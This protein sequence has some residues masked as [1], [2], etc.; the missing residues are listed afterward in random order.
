MTGAA[1]DR[2]A[3]PGETTAALN[4][5]HGAELAR[6]AVGA[7]AAHLSRLPFTPSP[8]LSEVLGRPGASFVTL[9][10]AGVLRGCVGTIEVARPLWHDVVRN[11]VRAAADPRLPAVTADEWPDL[12]IKL[13]VLSLPEPVPAPA[14]GELAARLRPGIDGLLLTDG[15]RRATFLPAVWTKLAEPDRFVAALLVKGGW[16]V[17]SWPVGL[18]AHRYTAVEFHDRAPRAALT[19]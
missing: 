9:E 16:P 6:L 12:D 18:V 1:R 7:L 4:P 2:M 11:A 17:G 8:P 15:E 13:S 19:A 10:C 14:A 5:T 3:P